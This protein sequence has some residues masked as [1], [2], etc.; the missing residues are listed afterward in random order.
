MIN[1]KQLKSG[2]IVALMLL[3][4]SILVLVTAYSFSNNSGL[5][6]RFIGWIFV[7]LTSIEFILQLKMQIR[8]EEGDQ[9]EMEADTRAHGETKDILKEIRGFAWLA[10]LLVLLY[11]FGFLVS[12]P[13]YILAFLRISAERPWKDSIIISV[14]ATL[15]VYLVFV[16]LLEY[17][18]FAG[19][20]FGA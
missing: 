1:V 11:L 18:L 10:L 12:V 6:P 19:I 2:F 14:S 5:F 4:I 15:F 3:I 7:A 8:S 13:V 9:R 20:L 16:Q 17:R